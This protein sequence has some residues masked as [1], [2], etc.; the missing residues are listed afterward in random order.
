MTESFKLDGLICDI[1]GEMIIFARGTRLIKC[2]K[3]GYRYEG[4]TGS[5]HHDELRWETYRKLNLGEKANS[6]E[7]AEFWARRVGP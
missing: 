7:E 3:C 2:N 1:C 6:E 5:K 4:V